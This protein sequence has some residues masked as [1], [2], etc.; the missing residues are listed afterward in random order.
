MWWGAFQGKSASG[1]PGL[2]HKEAN[3]APSTCTMG[4]PQG[5]TAVFPT[6]VFCGLLKVDLHIKIHAGNPKGKTAVGLVWA[7]PLE[8]HVG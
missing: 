2:I 4:N 3:G 8:L 6:W 7:H 1:P 5:K